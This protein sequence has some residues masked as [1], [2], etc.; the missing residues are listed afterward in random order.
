MQTAGTNLS[1]LWLFIHAADILEGED[2]M[3][4]QPAPEEEYERK[5]P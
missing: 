4:A 2:A 3:N 5:G 1:A